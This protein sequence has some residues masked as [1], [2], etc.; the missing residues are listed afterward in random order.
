MGCANRL[1]MSARKKMHSVVLSQAGIQLIIEYG[2]GVVADSSSCWKAWLS[3]VEYAKNEFFVS[4]MRAA[5]WLTIWSTAS[6]LEVCCWRAS[7]CSSV[8]NPVIVGMLTPSR[9]ICEKL[10]WLGTLPWYGD[11]FWSV[12]G[13]RLEWTKVRTGENIHRATNFNKIKNQCEHPC[14]GSI[15]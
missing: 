15:Q 8:Y 13:Q 6:P 9:A 3:L 4:T 11:P 1:T 7:S 10:K 14:E 2:H 5:K 12:S